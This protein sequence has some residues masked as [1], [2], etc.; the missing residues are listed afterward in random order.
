[1]DKVDGDV[2]GYDPAELA[3]RHALIDTLY[4]TGRLD[5][6]LRDRLV[7]TGRPVYAVWPNQSGQEWM[8]RT[9]GVPLRKFTASG[10][11]PPWSRILATREYGGDYTLTPLTPSAKL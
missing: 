3:V 11:A 8:R 9:P 10:M 5:G 1:M 2:R 4:R 7:R 6:A